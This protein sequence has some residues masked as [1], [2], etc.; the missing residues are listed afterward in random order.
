MHDLTRV[1]WVLMIFKLQIFRCAIHPCLTC[2]CALGIFAAPLALSQASPKHPRTE[3]SKP[4]PADDSHLYRNPA[5]GFRYKIP[6][7]WV[8]RTRE[9]R[10]QAAGPNSNSAATQGTDDSPAGKNNPAAGTADDSAPH[11]NSTSSNPKASSKSPSARNKAATPAPSDVLLAVFERPPAA[12][13]DTINSAVVIATES[14]SS[15]PGLKTA[16]DFLAPLTGL[17]SAQGFKPNGD[18][19]ALTIDTRELFRAD[20]TRQL[21]DSLTMHQ[22]TLVMVV[23]GQIL[24]FT[25]IA[26]SED[27]VDELIENL[28]FAGAPAR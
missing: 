22:S 17:A 6:Y 25:F 21:T 15:Y 23:K 4:A 19:S 5:F 2:A 28:G 27:E 1:I 13:G 8:D 20:F 10:E 7:G 16:A 12:P 26:G 9:M 18:P 24:S 14:L 3:S 11:P